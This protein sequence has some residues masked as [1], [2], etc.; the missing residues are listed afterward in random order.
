[1][2]HIRKLENTVRQGKKKLEK[3]PPRDMGNKENDQFAVYDKCRKRAM[4]E[5]RKSLRQILDQ[6]H[7]VKGENVRCA[8]ALK[9]QTRPI[10]KAQAMFYKGYVERSQASWEPFIQITMC[11]KLGEERRSE[12]AAKFVLD[13]EGHVKEGWTIVPGDLSQMCTE[14][15]DTLFNALLKV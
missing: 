1:M 11:A 5:A 9:P 4:F 8:V 15:H 12:I 7:K 13:F 3:K 2:E 14:F 10:W 6:N